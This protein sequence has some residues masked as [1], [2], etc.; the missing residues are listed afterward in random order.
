MEDRR[1]SSLAGGQRP[2][3]LPKPTSR[4]PQP[5]ASSIPAP[6]SHIRH[7]PSGDTL[8]GRFTPT[9]TTSATS[10]PRGGQQASLG[11]RPT[12][13]RE[14]LRP[15]VASAPRKPQRQAA[16]PLSSQTALRG[17]RTRDGSVPREA[18]KYAS[19]EDD[20]T[21]KK[22]LAPRKK[23]SGH[24]TSTSI[25]GLTKAEL[26][27]DDASPPDTPFTAEDSG[28]A[29]GR[30]LSQSQRPRLSL[31]ERTIE[32]LAQVSS[33]PAI[34]RQGSNFFDTEASLKRSPSRGGSSGSRPSSSYQ[35]DGSTI[36]SPSC[37]E[38]VTG[39][40]PAASRVLSA[41]YS[42]SLVPMQGTPSRKSSGTP[43]TPTMKLGS[44]PGRSPIRTDQSSELE[45]SSQDIL[46]ETPVAKNGAKTSGARVLRPKTSAGNLF[47]KPSIP[48]FNKECSDASKLTVRPARKVSVPSSRSSA[49][50]SE[51]RNLS[52]ASTVSTTLSIDS[53]EEPSAV[54]T[55]RKSSAALR[56]Q[57]AKA[58]AAKR[59][60]SRQVS[61]ESPANTPIKSPLIPTDTTFDFGLSDDPFNQQQ[62]ENSNRKVMQS[63]IEMAR[64]TG[65]LN[66]SAMGLKEIPQEVQ[67]MYDFES[68]GRTD[69]S[70]AESVDLTRLVAADNDLETI[71]D[72]IFPDANP[73]DH[74]EEDDTGHL[75]GGLESMDLHGNS[76]ITIPLGFRRLQQLTA[77]NL[78]QNKLT[79]GC[80]EIISQIPS[81]RDLKLGK[82]LFYGKIDSCFSALENLEILD[83][84]GNE[85]SSLPDGFENLSRLRILNV[86]ENAL[87][88]LPLHALSRMPLTELYAH[89]NK[90]AGTLI[91]VEIDTL[92]HLQT[93]DI[94]ANQLTSLSSGVVALP[95]LLQFTVS[96]NRLKLL[97]D[98][99]S[100][101]SLLTLIAEENNLAAIPDGF[102]SLQNLKHA[103]F[104]SN[105]IKVIPP[106]IARMDSL[107]M[108]RIS[109][110]PLRDKKLTSM[111]TEEVKDALAARLDPEES[112]F[113]N[114]IAPLGDVLD[115]TSVRGPAW[116]QHA[117][118]PPF[119]G[120]GIVA[121]GTA[122][123]YRS[124]TAGSEDYDDSRSDYD[125]FATPPTSAPQT[126]VRA[127]SNTAS[128]AT[129]PLK[130]G[131]ILDRANTQASS[132]NPVTCS[133]LATS[134]AVREV[135]L[136]HNMFTSFPRSL[137][138]FAE[139]LTSLS[140][141]HNQLNSEAYLGEDLDL[142]VLQE[143][144]LQHN[145]ISS[146]QPL[147][148][149]LHAPSLTRLDVSHNR[150]AMIP[151]AFTSVFP[152]LTVLLISNN[153][154]EE[155]DPDAVEGLKVLAAD[156]NDIGHLNP[157]L[158]LLKFE[159]LDV[160]GNRF[161]VPKWNILE[162]GTDST[163]RWLRGRVPAADMA[164]WKAK[165]GG[166]RN[167]DEDDTEY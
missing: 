36:I 45:T 19:A 93:L 79:N 123:A 134:Q 37:P 54:S 164:E 39:G 153:H 92:S 85:I 89:K 55:T 150:I 99:S 107:A 9:T 119:E 73:W 17:A 91:D 77:L 81:L 152:A 59:A 109:G 137:N 25:S 76:L 118:M 26:S 116:S 8:R 163:L 6:S 62:F 34:K 12:A 46:V 108:L 156:N 161:R 3:A 106:E 22:P 88:S 112:A 94:S 154:I 10:S 78:A 13:S 142:P 66:I 122:S 144:N 82:N 7:S 72:S 69:G 120:L 48:S 103:D 124:T 87:E 97:P 63:R 129:W 43:K 100:W 31:A 38:S 157:R 24:F 90:L 57:I 110:N 1:L 151:P 140:I 141:S 16:P 165:H 21:F 65:R 14:Q 96:M 159:R 11:L 75:F 51:E 33:S 84:R 113:H 147:A 138:F 105:D 115:C 80:L 2:S 167:E 128:S 42:Q 5:R 49:T 98:I 23:L 121:T 30:A 15:S 104:T 64:T 40:F 28:F 18:G 102:T 158:G 114:P 27:I 83:L 125:D 127:R 53:A 44:T 162:Q 60:A 95:S 155:L 70:W 160:M 74:A 52:S 47:K 126:P 139:T 131:G 145:H 61:S 146:L 101:K 67:K 135:R 41:G 20:S 143:L 166:N 50:T 86:S 68:I 132:L 29:V 117:T 35:S 4:L 148:T 149:H 130:P 71:D 136:Q 58:K 32:T 56:E 133:K 111:S